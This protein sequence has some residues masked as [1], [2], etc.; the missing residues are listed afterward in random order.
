MSADRPGG[1]R[2]RDLG[3]RPAAPA[4]RDQLA[5]VYLRSRD[6]AFPAM[7]RGIHP[8][9]EVRGWVAGW[10]LDAW[11]VWVAEAGGGPVGFCVVT[12]TWLHSLYV[13][14]EAA[15]SG[16]GSALLDL[17]KGLRP[18]GFCLWVFESNAPARGF[19][20]RRGLVPLE[21]TDGAANEERAPDVRMAWPGRDPLA[22]YRGLIDEVDS[23]LGDLLARRAALTRTVQEHKRRTGPPVSQ[24]GR[25]A[26]REREIAR[27]LAARAPELGA[28]RLARIL[29]VIISESLD[30]SGAEDDL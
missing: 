26:E 5:E 24:P 20:E 16:V 13:V 27:R 6:A 15:G 2:I 11:D 9:E 3:L 14:P 22:F 19:Y 8:P 21:R 25:D 29:H 28:E 17:A 18:D 30:A 23:E 4:D 7:P 1:T 10:D 12:E